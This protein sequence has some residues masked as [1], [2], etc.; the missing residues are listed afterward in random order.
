[1]IR[2]YTDRRK[3]TTVLMAGAV[4]AACAGVGVERAAAFRGG[5]G[6][7]HGGGFGGF[8]S[9]GFGGFH[10]GGSRFGDGGF[11]D[12]SG[13]AGF[14]RGG[15]GSVHNAGSFSDH[16]ET[17]RQSH[18]EYQHNASQFQQAHP[19][20][21]TN[22]SQLQ[23]NRT[24]EANNL[25]QNR[26]NEVND[27]QSNRENTFNNYNRNWGGLLLG[28]RIRRRSCHRRD[29]RCAAGRGRSDLGRRKPI[30]LLQ[31]HLLRAPGQPICRGATTARSS[32]CNATAV[33]LHRLCRHRAQSRLRWRILLHGAERL[34]GDPAT[35]RSDGDHATERC[36]RSEYQ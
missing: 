30:L 26:T 22:A 36:G 1:M 21:R 3:L 25:Q 12:H 5:F 33:L 23:Q 29:T 20:A 18:P 13:D 7:F 11:S 24:S 32:R 27:L 15:F 14:G 34:P 6:G 19:D 9:G 35:R 8:H 4:V 28:R 10:G 31:W 16:A 2:R 17:Y